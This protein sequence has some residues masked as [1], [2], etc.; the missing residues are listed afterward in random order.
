[1]TPT[2]IAHPAPAFAPTP[3][4]SAQTMIGGTAAAFISMFS[5]IALTSTTAVQ[6]MM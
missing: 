6:M 3:D 5:V 1:M 2:T 4:R